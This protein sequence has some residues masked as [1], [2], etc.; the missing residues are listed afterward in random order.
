MASIS[1]GS[2]LQRL[3]TL[4]LCRTLW[5]GF[6]FPGGRAA[7][8]AVERCAQ[9][10]ESTHGA[11]STE[12][13][14]DFCIC[15]VYAISG[16]GEEYRRR[17]RPAHSFGAKALE[18]FSATTLAR[19]YYEDRWLHGYGLTREGLA[20]ETGCGEHPLARFVF[21]EWEELTKRRLLSTEAGYLVCGS[22][23][24]LWTPQSPVCGRCVLRDRCR[25]RTRRLY[26]ELYRLRCEALEKA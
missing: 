8:C 5:P 18:R 17:W 9:A 2:N 23:T 26:P 11:L 25:E 22:S 6:R 12:R 14:A 4:I 19:R 15:Q 10:L 3:F 20:S 24:L 16:Y 21:P 13:V 7:E 1:P